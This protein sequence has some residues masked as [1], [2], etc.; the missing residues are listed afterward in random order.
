MKV[1]LVQPGAQ[2][3]MIMNVVP[4]LGLGYLASSIRDEYEVKILDC[5][6]DKIDKEKFEIY[7]ADYDPDVI[8][9]TLYSY[10]ISSVREMVDAIKEKKLHTTVIIGGPHSSAIK[11]KIFSELPKIDFGFVGEGE[12]GFPELLHQIE[13]DT[14]DFDNIPGLI[15]QKNGN[16]VANKQIFP[17]DLDKINFPAWDLIRPA[18]YPPIP[19][20]LILEAY[21]YAP[22][23]ISRGC[24]YPCTFCA[25]K[26]ITGKKVRQ[27]SVENV[28]SEIELLIKKYN[29]KEIHIEDDNFT[30]NKEYVMNF[31]NEILHRN[32]R[33]KFSTPNGVRLE[34]LDEEILKMMKKV[35]WY[36]IFSGIESGSDRILDKMKKGITTKEIREKIRIIKKVGL[37]TAGYFII[38]YPGETVEEINKTI[39]FSKE[40]NLDW[41]HFSFFLPL[42]GTEITNKLMKEK[43]L[44]K[45]CWSK[46]YDSKVAYSTVDIPAVQLQKLQRMAY[47][48]FY[49][50]IKIILNLIR[51]IRFFR[52]RFL[53][54]RIN[55]YIIKNG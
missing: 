52:I 14:D 15:W 9:F 41:A 37:Q 1:L 17:D 48:H 6:K 42:P 45:I 19:N 25:A 33:I 10:N 8:G 22:I 30:I 3:N 5:I 40:L 53:M 50:R 29:I 38:G 36:V 4:P 27:R 31:C 35:G 2:K 26:T 28:I 18:K 12:I 51:K 24:P 34:T 23:I 13:K 44:G 7:L 11:E 55:A 43:K 47:I 49:L 54:R 39:T 20:G 32:I 21:P 16:P 46:L